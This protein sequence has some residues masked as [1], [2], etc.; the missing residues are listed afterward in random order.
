MK[1][2]VISACIGGAIVTGTMAVLEGTQWVGEKI[3]E[4]ST[5]GLLKLSVLDTEAKEIRNVANVQHTFEKKARKEMYKNKSII[6]KKYNG[7]KKDE[8][9]FEAVA[10]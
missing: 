4:W 5:E 1:L 7:K 6:W 9:K 8:I 2:K 3:D 10:N